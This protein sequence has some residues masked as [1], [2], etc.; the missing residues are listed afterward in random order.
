M[1]QT[2]IL[3]KGDGELWGRLSYDPG[4]DKEGFLHTTVGANVA[5]ITQNIRDLV[6]DSLE[7]ELKD[8]PYWAGVN[9]NDIEFNYVYDLTAFFEVFNAVKINVIAEKAGINKALARQYASGVKHPS[10][11]QAKK[12]EKAVHELANELLQVQIA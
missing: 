4:E 7:H 3:E 11:Q 12:I 5:E 1:K 10:A 9:P 6:T 8:D 2:I